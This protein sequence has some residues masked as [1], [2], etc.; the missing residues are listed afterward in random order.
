[1]K[2]TVD[3]LTT[4]ERDT[5]AHF[6]D[7]EAY[8]VLKKLASLEIVSLGKDALTSLDHE[9]TRFLAGQATM[10]KNFIEL[11]QLCY[12][13]SNKEGWVWFRCPP[14]EPDPAFAG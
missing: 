6:Y 10:A 11:I 7:T 4:K 13:A 3:Q 1:M 2:S 5:L 12:K 9:Q 14:S 8:L